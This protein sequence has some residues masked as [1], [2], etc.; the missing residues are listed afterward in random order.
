MKTWKSDN[1]TILVDDL[2]LSFYRVPHQWTSINHPSN[3][4]IMKISWKIV[5]SLTKRVTLELYASK[6]RVQ[7]P[8]LQSMFPFMSPFYLRL[9]GK[10][11][12][13]VFIYVKSFSISLHTSAIFIFFTHAI[14]VESIVLWYHYYWF[15]LAHRLQ[16]Y[17]TTALHI[18]DFKNEFFQNDF[19]M[20]YLFVVLS[21]F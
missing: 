7:N 14:W 9:V 18:E 19:L 3:A 4:S 10:L 8:L 13:W 1:H 11:H 17:P 20:K 12:L 16:F 5:R 15:F 2:A 21:R 6:I